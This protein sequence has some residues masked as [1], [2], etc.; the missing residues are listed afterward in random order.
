MTRRFL[1]LSIL[2][3]VLFLALEICA[4]AQT[5]VTGFPPLGTFAGG[6][7]DTVNLANLNVHFAIPIFSRLGKGIPFSYALSYDGLVWSPTTSSGAYGW[8][9]VSSNWG[10]RAVTEAATGYVSFNTLTGPAQS[11]LYGHEGGFPLY[12]VSTTTWQG[13][14]YH[15]PSGGIHPLPSTATIQVVSISNSACGTVGTTVYPFTNQVTTDNSGYFVTSNSTS[16]TGPLTVNARGGLIITTPSLGQ[17]T[18]AGSISDAN[19]NTIQI[20]YTQS[21]QTTTITDTLGTTALTITGLPPTNAPTCT[22]AS[23]TSNVTYQ[24]TAP[25]GSAATITASYANNEVQTNFEAG[26]P[27]F[28]LTNECL[29][30][31]I[32]LPDGTYYQFGYESTNFGGGSSPQTTARMASVSLPTGGSVNYLYD[33]ASCYNSDNCIMKDGSPT[34]MTRELTAG[35]PII[36]Q[37]GTWSYTRAV[38]SGQQLP[39][40]N[41]TVIDP[42]GNETDLNFSGVYATQNNTNNG[43]GSSKSLLKNVIYCYNGNFTNCSAA[44]VTPPITSQWAYDELTDSGLYKTSA[45]S[46]DQ[47]GNVTG[48][49]DYGYTTGSASV[50]R[51]LTVS[52]NSTLCSAPKNICDHPSSVQINDGSSHQYALTN[53]SNY[54]GN[55]NIK[56][57]DRWTS[58]SNYLSSYYSYNTSSNYTLSTA[59]DPNGTV[60]NYTYGSGSCNGAFPTSVAVGS[61]TTQYSYNCSGGV[62]TSIIDPNGVTTATT[63]TDPYFWRPASTTDA[64]QN[65][66]SFTYY[67]NAYLSGYP[68]VESVL[69]NSGGGAVVDGLTMLDAYGRVSL[70]QTREGSGSGTWDTVEYLYD[71]N[72]RTDY[73]TLPF[74]GS[75]GVPAGSIPST[76]YSYDALNR[77]TVI[78]TWNG[79]S[80]LSYTNFT[81]NLNDVKVTVNPAPTGENPKSHQ[82][83][84]DALGRLTSVCEM[85]SMTG[86]GTCPQQTGQ[87]GFYTSYAY[88]PLGDLTGVSQSGQTRSYSYDG[89]SRITQETNPESGTTGY[90]YDSLS[91]SYCSSTSKGDL[92][93][94]SDANGNSVCYHYDGLHRLTDVG[95]NAQSTN[96]PCLRFRYDNSTGVNG[97]YPSGISPTYYY[98]RMVEA[99]TDGCTGSG[100]TVTDEWFSYSARGDQT[101]AWESTPHSGGWYHLQNQYAANGAISVRLGYLGTGTSTAFANVLAYGMDGEGRANSLMDQTLNKSLWSG[102]TYSA[103]GEPNQLQFY[104]GDKESFTWDPNSDRMTAWTSNVGSLHQTGNLTWNANGTLQQ[105]ALIDTANTANSQ[106]CNYIY[107]DLE[108]ISSG[109][110]SGSLWGQDF[111]YD[112]FGNIKKTVPPSY[113]GITF[114]PNYNSGNQLTNFSYDAGGHVTNDGTNI[115]TYNAEG[116][117]ATVSGTAVVYDA[118]TRLV[119]GP[120]PSGTQ[121]LVYA[122]D[123]FKFAYMNG[124]TVQKYIAPLAAGL[125]AVYT[126]ATPAAPAFWRHSDWQGT[127]R[128][129]STPAQTV[130]F[131]GAYGPFGEQYAGQGTSDRVFTWQTAD[132]LTGRYEFPFRQYDP[133][134]GRWML[135]DPSG[136]AAVDI[137]NPQ[138]WNRYAYVANNPLR[139]VDPLGLH[140]DCGG[141]AAN[142]DDPFCNGDNAGGGGGDSSNCAYDACV[143]ASP[144]DAVSPVDTGVSQSSGVNLGVNVISWNIGAYRLGNP[145]TVPHTSPILPSNGQCT[146]V[147]RGLK[148]NTNKVGLQGG[149]PGIKV[150]LGTAAVIPQQFGFPSGAALAPYAPY[151]YGTVGNASFSGISDVIGGKS[152]MPPIPVR[153]EL[154]VLNPGNVIIEIPGATDQG[155]NAPYTIFVPKGVGCP[156]GNLV[157]GGS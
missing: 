16:A 15:D 50:I 45:Q 78:S 132:M 98:G 55:G 94:K 120:G 119:E 89:L 156:S 146:G 30:N 142:S 1:L 56:Q 64:S 20:A 17:S 65:K 67:T 141:S 40:T 110:C 143:V 109:L 81:Y 49:N 43:N 44:T 85:T 24:Y 113:T 139:N 87:T 22:N 129:D 58:G 51:N 53:Y 5:P 100:S 116:R 23:G 79:E 74:A 127:T 12:G 7:F 96:N 145:A 26:W 101:D 57:I 131:D 137:T 84:Y 125:L 41:T 102:T 48:E 37:A 52:Y 153:S 130:Y 71:S 150:Q 60:T 36:D 54:D 140:L 10:W 134:E 135:P 70:K 4:F 13:F 122:P 63:Y 11:C 106:T 2:C 3:V 112:V 95:N 115:Y 88:D 91:A 18:G 121:Q 35:T 33:G 27:E 157:G 21:T 136:L 62:V 118:F 31:K 123:G 19:G 6:P 126:S 90:T 148:G 108:R 103:A 155:V 66:T 144:P 9:P 133:A 39:Q 151:I 93:S 105:M 128:V 83:E 8:T 111:T 99:E 124:Q 14:E 117:M 61:L 68:G 46:Y 72:G 59:T 77:Y 80:E 107:D 114:T 76:G 154:Q 69:T 25:N 138:T 29:V 32:S 86:S 97:S 38:Q 92:V 82:Y 104:S 47:Y 28:Q 152:P 42:S 149:I 73:V 34:V 147:G 75:A